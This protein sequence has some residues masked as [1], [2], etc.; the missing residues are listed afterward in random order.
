MVEAWLGQNGKSGVSGTFDQ[1][2]LSGRLGSIPFLTDS[3]SYE[4]FARSELGEANSQLQQSGDRPAAKY[5]KPI[6]IFNAISSET[7][8]DALVKL[9]G[10]Y[11][12]A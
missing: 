6:L 12:G 3:F 4:L 10:R 7:A 11:I 1:G 5:G 8:A 9:R 2:S